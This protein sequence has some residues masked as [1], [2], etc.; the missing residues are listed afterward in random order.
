MATFGKVLAVINVL[1]AIAF[2]WLAGMDYSK[3]QNW[4]YAYYRGQLGLNGLPV[5]ANDPGR[6]PGQ[7]VS[8]SLGKGVIADLFRGQGPT[9]NTQVEEVTRRQNEVGKEIDQADTLKS[10]TDVLS[11]YLLPLATRGDERD[12]LIRRLLNVK[13]DNDIEDLKKNVLDGYFARAISPRTPGTATYPDGEVRDL[14]DRRRSIADLL[15]NL[16]ATPEGRTRTQAVVGIAQYVGAADRQFANL[17]AM[18]DRLRTAI[19]AD[20]VNFVGEYR[21]AVDAL[22][23]EAAHLQHY[24]TKLTEQQEQVR[25][26]TVLRNARQEEARVLQQ[27]IEKKKQEAAAEA[28]TLDALQRRLFELQQDFVKLQAGN[29]RLEREIEVKET[30][31]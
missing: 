6:Q 7:D 18:I 22:G 3:R 23:K 25:K 11:K 29:Q 12:E 17:R 31:K 14:E 9:V 5:D 10:K 13:G 26:A 1:A 21:A 24:E 8:K 15:Y 2:L 16:D 4:A 28:A 19:A 20:Q 30:G 27:E